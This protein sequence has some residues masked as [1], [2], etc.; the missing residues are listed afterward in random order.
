MSVYNHLSK[1][2]FA[3]LTNAL[4]TLPTVALA[5][6]ADVVYS[7]DLVFNIDYSDTF[8]AQALSQQLQTQ[9]QTTL[10]NE[11]FNLAFPE[12]NSA[13]SPTSDAAQVDPE[14]LNVLGLSGEFVSAEISQNFQ[15][16]SV[17]LTHRSLE[18][19]YLGDEFMTLTQWSPH[20]TGYIGNN[21]AVRTDYIQSRKSLAGRPGREADVN[22][23]AANISWFIN[24]AKAY[25]SLG[26]K[27]DYEDAVNPEHDFNAN[28]IRLKL[29]KHFPFMARNGVIKL[30][31]SYEQR[32]Y[33]NGF[34]ELGQ[35]R[36]EG[37]TRYQAEL[38]LPLTQQ[39]QLILNA[40]FADHESNFATSERETYVTGAELNLSF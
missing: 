9:G 15:P 19:S 29:A 27:Y 5:D 34:S 3:M 25:F 38:E 2:A 21:I 26:A 22:S 11:G 32:L 7:G 20:V 33:K 35:P 16:I 23:L 40:E 13:Q 17:G 39:L 14:L 36:E 4:L 24:G 1:F 18:A 10:L 6:E 30:G 28:T 12:V 8:Q 31:A 37:R